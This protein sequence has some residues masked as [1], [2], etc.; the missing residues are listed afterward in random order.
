MPALKSKSK[1]EFGD[2]QTPAGLADQICRSLSELHPASVLEP[3]CGTGSLLL[4]AANT[5]PGAKQ[6]VGTDIN[7][8]YV[9]QAKSQLT[10]FPHA[11][12]F[13]GDF[14]SAD[15]P[16][17]LSRLADPLLVIGNPP[18]VTNTELSKLDSSNLP[19][20]ANF[21]ERRGMDALTGKSNFDISEWMLIRLCELLNGRRATLA[22]LCKTVVARKV[23]RHNW[24]NC[25]QMQTA[26]IRKIDAATAFG[27][28]VD[29]CLLTVSF[30]RGGCAKECP[31]FD[32]LFEKDPRSGVAYRNG[33]LLSD[34]AAYEELQHLHGA[35]S[36]RWRSGVKHDCSK[37][38]E[39]VKEGD[40]YR[41]G[42]AELAELEPHYL[43]PTL[44]T[45]DV[46]NGRTDSPRRCLL[47]TQKSVG[48][49]TG[50]I[51]ETA[52]KTW[53]YLN[54][55]AGMLDARASSIYR[56]RPRFSIFG[57]GD[58][59]FAPWKVAISGF[60]KKLQFTEVGSFC[61]KPIMLDDATYFLPCRT[62]RDAER[63]ARLLN[64]DRA[65]RFLEAFI[66]WDSKR[67]ITVDV[68]EQLNLDVL[69]NARSRLF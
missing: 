55:H 33:W 30:E 11:E 39:F 34:V 14:F 24:R 52:P 48:E 27:A 29:A 54:S 23:L 32:D 37:V 2:F 1:A 46:A 66:F 51:C 35:D 6:I 42:L 8:S 41:N 20:K 21:Q 61:G 4:A 64:S 68:L 40:K 47:V 7:P 57:I 45:S 15:W 38:M 17:V 13:R 62:Q 63:L 56:K 31:V 22:M 58:Y 26:S 25:V 59:S 18:W 53:E 16:N 49:D 50:M 36:Y 43:Y 3:T 60:Y 28:A 5:F 10:F 69:E 9:R 44:K 19:E 65:K 67:P 12:V